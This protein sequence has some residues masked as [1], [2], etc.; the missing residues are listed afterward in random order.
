V[1][2]HQGESDTGMGSTEYLNKMTNAIQASNQS[3]GWEF[4][5][6]VAQA[7]YHSPTASA[8]AGIRDAQKRLWDTGIALEGPD[9]DTLTGDNRD[10]NG[11]GIHMSGKGERAHGELWADKV[12]RYLSAVLK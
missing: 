7:T 10:Q 8:F 12:S 4:P 5:W 2:W 1:L 9:T 6:L 11:A 3:A